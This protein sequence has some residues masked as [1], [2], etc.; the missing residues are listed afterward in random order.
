M[1]HHSRCETPRFFTGTYDTPHT[2]SN[3]TSTVAEDSA[4]R[5]GPGCRPSA[6]KQR[7]AFRTRDTGLTTRKGEPPD[8][9]HAK[10]TSTG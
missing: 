2:M 9:N 8:P 4:G 1:R 7:T 6:N 10:P 3:T 5:Q